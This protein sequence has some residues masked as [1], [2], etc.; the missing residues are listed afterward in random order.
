MPSRRRLQQYAIA[1]SILSLFYNTAEGVVSVVFGAESSS[2][3]LVFYGL[4]SAVEVISDFLVTW[5]FLGVSKPG[6][7]TENLSKTSP[8]IIR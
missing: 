5:R 1:I 3:A 4:Q 2:H 6:D 8:Q 7:E